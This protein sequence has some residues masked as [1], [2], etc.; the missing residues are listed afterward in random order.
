MSHIRLVSVHIP[1]T[2]C[3]TTMGF[4]VKCERLLV[5]LK[6]LQSDLDRDDGDG[7]IPIDIPNHAVDI[8]QIEFIRGETATQITA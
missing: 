6:C 8:S 1:Q 5:L 2:V 7:S 3:R 4:R